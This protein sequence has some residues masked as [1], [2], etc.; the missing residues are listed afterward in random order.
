MTRPCG[1]GATFG[2][3]V[4]RRCSVDTVGKLTDVTGVVMPGL[5][6][7]QAL[8]SEPKKS[9]PTNPPTNQR[10]LHLVEALSKSGEDVK[11]WTTTTWGNVVKASSKPVHTPKPKVAS[12]SLAGDT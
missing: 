6:I 1:G 2:A 9:P 11:A 10:N 5:E 7:H 12:S 3:K 4:P 8:R